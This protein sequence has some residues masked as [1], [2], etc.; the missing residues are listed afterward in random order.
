MIPNSVKALSGGVFT[1]CSALTSV[2]IPNGV[3]SLGEREF[4]GCSSLIS[5]TIPDSMKSFGD[6]AFAA[7]R[8]LTTIHIPNSVTRFGDG[9]FY[10]CTSL[11]SVTIPDKVTYLGGD[12]FSNC[13]SLTT[14]TILSGAKGFSYGA[15]FDCDLLTIRCYSGSKAHEYVVKNKLPFVLLD[16][17]ALDAIVIDRAAL[18]LNVGDSTT[19][20]AKYMPENA[21]EKPAVV[22]ASSN[23]NVATVDASGKVT[24]AA[25]GTATVT[26]TVNAQSGVKA[27]TCAVTVTKPA[28]EAM[29]QSPVTKVTNQKSVAK[30]TTPLKTVYLKKGA[31]LTI[32]AV[33]YYSDGAIAK[34]KWA[35]NNAAVAKVNASGK[36]TAKKRGTAKITATAPDGKRVTVTVKVVAKAKKLTKISMPKAPKSLKK[37]KTTQLTIKVTPATATNL[38]VTFKSSKPSVLSVDKVGKLTAKKKGKATITVKAGGKS[39]KKT[40]NVK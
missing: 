12:A 19:L 4:S 40:I 10:G 30:I 34:L 35:S 37:G 39:A 5:V 36:V 11:T 13:S 27:A 14:A 8:S 26:A 6:Y 17:I 38:K 7:C 9:A 18:A 2:T 24:G 16:A 23:S 33:A 31:S 15:F 29:D 1:N 21:E 22:W 25:E 20:T 28:E 3:A 32:P